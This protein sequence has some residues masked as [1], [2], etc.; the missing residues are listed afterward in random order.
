VSPTAAGQ[1]LF[2]RIKEMLDLLEQTKAEVAALGAEPTW[3]RFGLTPGM[4]NMLSSDLLLAAREELPGL[5]IELVEDVS[6][7][8]TDLVKQ[9][10]LDAALVY[11]MPEYPEL[12]RTPLFREELLFVTAPDRTR[13]AKKSSVA[14][15][16]ND[17]I[18][19]KD[20]LNHDLVLAGKRNRLRRFIEESAIEYATD[21]RIAFEVQSIQ[22]IKNLI[23]RGHGTS[24]M[25]YG[26]LAN[27]LAEGHLQARRIVPSTAAWTIY[28]VQQRKGHLQHQ[29]SAFLQLVQRMTSVWIRRLGPLATAIPNDERT[30]ETKALAE[31]V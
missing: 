10:D 16:L 8:L 1:L 3:V 13:R 20:V 4:A 24:I 19:L 18:S 11:E 26:S 21:L 12:E 2:R 29:Q 30:T 23:S 31:T 27:D 22:A 9:G 28:L 14:D 25:P 5:T 6:Y 15:V 17:P 7:V